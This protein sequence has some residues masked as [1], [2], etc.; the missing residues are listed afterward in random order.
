[1]SDNTGGQPA[2][3]Q[4]G[5]PPQGGQSPQG[6]QPAQGGQLGAEEDGFG[7]I[8]NRE[9]TTYQLK[10]GVALFAIIGLGIGISIFLYDILDD[11]SAGSGTFLA[12]TSFLVVPLLGAVLGLS[13]S[14]ALV[15]VPDNLVYGTAAITAA[16]GAIVLGLVTW[17][18]GEIVF[19]VWTDLGDLIEIWIAF[20]I[21]GAIVAAGAVAIDRKL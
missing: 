7:D 5:Q 9:D 16:A 11:A 12:Q 3:G 2:G 4:G 21:G 18:F 14:E 8:F 6:G 1:M 17:L 19:D 15:D 20:A 13:Q 10:R